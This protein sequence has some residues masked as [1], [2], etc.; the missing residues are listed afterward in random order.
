[1]SHCRTGSRYAARSRGAAEFVLVEATSGSIHFA[2]D[3]SAH[4]SR[5]EHY[6]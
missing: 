2:L 4:L 5:G 6:A 3:A 1:M